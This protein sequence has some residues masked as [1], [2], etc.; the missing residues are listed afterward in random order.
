M[1]LLSSREAFLTPASLVWQVLAAVLA[2][3]PLRCVPTVTC[4]PTP[5]KAY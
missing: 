4:V 3:P 5:W 2:S 1:P